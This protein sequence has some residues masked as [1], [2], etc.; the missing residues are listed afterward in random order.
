MIDRAELKSI[1]KAQ[2]NGNIGSFF[3]CYLVYFLLAGVGSIFVAPPLY[4]GLLMAFLGLARGENPQMEKMFEGF[5]IYGKSMLT[6]LAMQLFISLWS[7]LLIVP[8]IIKSLEYTFAPYILIESPEMSAMES[9]R[10]SKDMTNGYK[11]ELFMLHLS[12]IPWYLLCT[13][14]F[15]IAGIYFLPYYQATITNLY[16]KIKAQRQN[17]AE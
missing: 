14:T 15:G 13:I 17:P 16:N 5:H 8:G 3:M 2:I 11:M 9:I 4:F 10:T 7:L 12:F 1:A 6:W